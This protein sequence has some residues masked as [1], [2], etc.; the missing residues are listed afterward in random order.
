MIPR[1]S[2][3]VAYR[4][5]R[6]AKWD[7]LLCT[8]PPASACR[9]SL[10]LAPVPPSGFDAFWFFTDSARRRAALR[11]PPGAAERYVLYGLD[12]LAE[13]G[14]GVRHNLE[15]PAPSGLARRAERVLNRRLYAAG[16]FG[17][18]FGTVLSS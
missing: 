8:T 15:G 13:R 17:G 3:A 10:Y 6:W 14:V 7:L 16:G 12:Q 4:F 1:R 18:E 9:A 11:A 2:S 5:T